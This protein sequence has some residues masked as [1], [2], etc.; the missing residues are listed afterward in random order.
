MKLGVE[1]KMNKSKRLSS[2]LILALCLSTPIFA[3]GNSPLFVHIEREIKEKEPAWKLVHRLV[4]KNSKYVSYQWKLGKS[5]VRVLIFVHD[6][7]QQ[8]SRTYHNFDLEAFG[9]KRKA[10]EETTLI[11]GD[12]N[13][14]WEDFNDRRTT[15]I[16]FRKGKVFVHL[17]TR[18]MDIAKRFAIYIAGVVPTR[19]VNLH[20][21]R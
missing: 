7:T 2:V 17:S 10:L 5:S 15:G 6:T 13:Y 1:Q 8:A 18:S 14:A 21:N 20:L 19:Q 11:L 3:Q 4:S 16:D 12:E 9:L